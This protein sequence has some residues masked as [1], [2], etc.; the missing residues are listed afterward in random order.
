MKEKTMDYYKILGVDTAATK[1]EIRA[2]YRK[3][4]FQYHPD[5][6]ENDN[7]AADM[8]KKINEAYA[9]LSDEKK[10]RQYDAMKNQYGDTAYDQF[11][12]RFT[13]HDIFKGSDIKGIFEELARDFGFRN[14]DELFKGTYGSAFKSFR[15]RSKDG[16]AQGFVF[17]GPL[18]KRSKTAQG[19]GQSGGLLSS[20]LTKIGALGS[21]KPGK[22]RHDKITLSLE[23]ATQGGPY[24]Y[25]IKESGT[26]LLVKVP[27]GI[28]NGQKIRLAGM[29]KAGVHGGPP[30]DLYLKVSVRRNLL[31]ILSHLSQKISRLFKRKA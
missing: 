12:D 3:L 28:R 5:R 31:Q 29:G 20:I 24:A 23:H 21:P 22:D 6:N 18:F 2:A 26:R 11:R 9:V 25:L 19:S 8:M 13:E 30:G 10:K 14:F 1:N 7:Q 16:G 4:A 17:F 27:P 15:F